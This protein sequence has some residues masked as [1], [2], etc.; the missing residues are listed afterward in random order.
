MPPFSITAAFSEKGRPR[1]I[2]FSENKFSEF[3]TI[4][5]TKNNVYTPTHTTNT[6]IPQPAG[7]TGLS[8]SRF[9]LRLLRICRVHPFLLVGYVLIKGFFCTVHFWFLFIVLTDSCSPPRVA[10]DGKGRYINF[11]DYLINQLI[12][13]ILLPELRV[14]VCR[15]PL[16]VHSQLLQVRIP[17]YKAVLE[18]LLDFRFY[19]ILD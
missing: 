13:L 7:V 6:I 14:K 1:Q 11:I 12:F 3:K 17:Y 8:S 16:N 5:K 9:K 15:A 10:F 19:I 2:S 4:F 18:I